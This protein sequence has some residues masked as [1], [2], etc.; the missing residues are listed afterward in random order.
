MICLA[1]DPVGS[2]T[3]DSMAG[4]ASSTEAKRNVDDIDTSQEQPK[5]KKKAKSTLKTNRAAAE[6]RL[7]A[8]VG[9]L[10]K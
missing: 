8:A 9:N 3:S 7:A 2:L 5:K 10:G 4:L 6:V 1:G